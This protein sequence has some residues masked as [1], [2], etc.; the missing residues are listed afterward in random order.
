M[1]KKL[2][3]V[4]TIV[5]LLLFCS[6][7]FALPPSVLDLATNSH[8]RNSIIFENTGSSPISAGVVVTFSASDSV[9]PAGN[10]N[11]HL[12]V[13]PF[14]DGFR[15]NM[16]SLVFDRGNHAYLSPT[17][18][19]DLASNPRVSGNDVDIGAYEYQALPPP[20]SPPSAMQVIFTTST[21]T[22]R[23]CSNASVAITVTGGV[24]PYDFE[25]RRVGGDDI[26]QHPEN[27]DGQLRLFNVVAGTYNF[28][29]FDSEDSVR[30]FQVPVH[31]EHKQI[32]PSILVTPNNDGLNDY[33]FIYEIDFFPINRVTIFNSYG[34]EITIIK[35][36][37]NHD[38]SRRWGGKNR[39]NNF[40]PDGTYWYVIQAEGVPPMT[41]WIIVRDSPGK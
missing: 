24:P 22:N 29:I 27:L 17:D 19:L 13:T 39:R 25:W 26:W 35:N 34:A 5:L 3:M 9:L 6:T 16:E 33:L 14:S 20:P 8:V 21:A 36:F 2:S 23:E 12:P 30:Q 32:M 15:I 40:V 41:G 4:A 37:C 18:T 11:M 28:T 38:P 1:K 7:N 10:N 31:C